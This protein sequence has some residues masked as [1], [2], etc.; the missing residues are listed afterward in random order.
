MTVCRYGI[1]SLDNRFLHQQQQ[2]HT[3]GFVCTCTLIFRQFV[4]CLLLEEEE[5]VIKA[6]V[7]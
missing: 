6:D 2:V 1:S 5:A 3:S 4:E 7:R